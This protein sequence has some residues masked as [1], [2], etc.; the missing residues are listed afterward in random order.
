[1]QQAHASIW[2][3]V[4]LVFEAYKLS[5]VT[6]DCLAGEYPLDSSKRLC[7]QLLE[8]ALA[9]LPA[10]GETLLGV[11]DLSGFSHRNTDF[12]FVRFLASCIAPLTGPV[13]MLQ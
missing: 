3:E 10:D 4:H 13:S 9:G 11:F 5:L 2:R 12:G 6:G 1:M 7:V 8:E